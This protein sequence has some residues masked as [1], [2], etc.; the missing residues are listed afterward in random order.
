VST[1]PPDNELD[2]SR[3][4]PQPPAYSRALLAAAV[5]VTLVVGGGSWWLLYRPGANGASMRV[6]LPESRPLE[7]PQDRFPGDDHAGDTP[8]PGSETAAGLPAPSPQAVLPAIDGP[9]IAAAPQAGQSGPEGTAERRKG[10]PVLIFDAG[11][12]PAGS[13]VRPGDGRDGDNGIVITTLPNPVPVPTGPS[14]REPASLLTR[15]TLIPAVLESAIDGGQPGGVRAVVTADVRSYDGKRVLI[16]RSSKL[17]GQYRTSSAG[18]G[19]KTYVIWTRIDRPDGNTVPLGTAG[20]KTDKA[21]LESFSAARMQSIVDGGSA[22]RVR[23][24]EP[25]R[26]YA[27]GD[28]EVAR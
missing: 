22:S 21:F 23:T 6:T 9:V 16:P 5:A 18:T 28:I 4:E 1:T 24:G 14:R 8:A 10:S 20:G 25:I 15:G 17:L 11:N 26:V 7:Y 19:A 2:L 12:P 13:G 27:A 3:F